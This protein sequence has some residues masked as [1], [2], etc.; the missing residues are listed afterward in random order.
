[1][2]GEPISGVYEED[3][4]PV[5]YFQRAR[6]E[7]HQELGP[8][9]QVILGKLG[10]EIHGPAEA[11]VPNVATPWDPD[12]RYFPQ[13]GHIVSHA[14][15]TFFDE[16]GG[17]TMLGFPLS[18]ARIENGII[19]QWFE[20]ARLEW[21]PEN[22][23]PYRVQLGL[24]GQERYDDIGPAHNG[25]YFQFGKVW[26]DNPRVA[27][28]IGNAMGEQVTLEMTEQYFEGGFILT[29]AGTNRI[30]VI[31]EGGQWES[32]QDTYR[33]GDVFERDFP[34]PDDKYEPTGS[35]GKIW[36]GLG[37]PGSR[38]GWAVEEERSFV[39]EYQKM[40]RGFMVR[41]VREYGGYD[42]DDSDEQHV[43]KWIYVFYNDGSWEL[44]EDLFEKSYMW[45]PPVLDKY[46]RVKF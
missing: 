17:E 21:H 9:F 36:W 26:E 11:P 3:G 7:W 5:Q 19:V 40:E 42:D 20:K 44:Y 43:F 14:F 39:G 6:F 23:P 31:Y 22:P 18:E 35:F 1:M 4:I 45:R 25:P 33:K 34:V 2:F 24:I 28:G 13:T 10:K 12:Q 15:L 27:S 8:G 37:G 46:G 38:L 16:H 41:I 30:Y 32:F 29:W